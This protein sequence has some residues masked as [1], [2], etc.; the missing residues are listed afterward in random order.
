MNRP[1]RTKSIDQAAAIQAKTGIVPKI[2]FQETGI[3]LFEFPLSPDVTNVV[4]S[5]ESGCLVDARNVLTIRNQ[6]FRR[7]KGGV[8]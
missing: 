5:Y 2:I 1:Y 7:L 8:K 6:I 3:A 4:L